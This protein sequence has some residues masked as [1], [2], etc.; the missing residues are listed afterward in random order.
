M[1]CVRYVACWKGDRRLIRVVW[2]DEM[3]STTSCDKNTNGRMF[4]LTTVVQVQ[5]VSQHVRLTGRDSTVTLVALRNHDGD[6]ELGFSIR[7]K[8]TTLIPSAVNVRLE[9]RKHWRGDP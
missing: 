3:L 6:Q 8:Q 2:V 1:G 5:V 7:S 9:V 4:T